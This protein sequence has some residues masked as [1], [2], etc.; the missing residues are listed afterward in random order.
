MKKSYTLLYKLFISFL[1]QRNKFSFFQLKAY[2]LEKI[3]NTCERNKNIAFKNAAFSLTEKICSQ[4]P[5]FELDC[6]KF[7]SIN[8][9]KDR[10]MFL[11]EYFEIVPDDAQ[12]P[13]FNIH[14][15]NSK[16]FFANTKGSLLNWSDGGPY[17]IEQVQVHPGDL[18]LDIGANMGIFSLL[19]A[20]KGG[21]VHAFEPQPK[22]TSILVKNIHLNSA[23]EIIIPHQ[24][25]VGSTDGLIAL[26]EMPN[27][28]LGASIT[29]HRSNTAHMVDCVTL[30]AWF[31]KSGLKRV[32]FIKAD[33]EGA[34]RLMLDGAKHILRIFKPKLAI[35]TY[36]LTDDPIVL[37]EKIRHANPEYNI[38]QGKT[39]LY[40]W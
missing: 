37:A 9:K 11:F 6:F 31:E 40:A 7:T 29:I 26:Y 12:F 33:I 36:H 38:I 2:L 24:L 21:R 25:A 14:V 5:Y 1:K 8:E 32:D 17:E 3:Q 15:K 39:K 18:V 22:M 10:Y 34:E 20:K 28:H 16:S 35:C 13:E 23:Q 30:D 27:N 4:T 19:A